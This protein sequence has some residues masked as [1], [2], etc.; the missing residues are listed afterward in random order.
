MKWLKLGDGWDVCRE[1]ESW[2]TAE[3]LSQNGAEMRES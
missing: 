1:K 2:V 3:R